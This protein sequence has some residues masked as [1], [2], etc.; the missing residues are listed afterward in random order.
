[1]VNY[2]TPELAEELRKLRQQHRKATERATAAILDEG[3]ASEAYQ[4]ADVE[5]GQAWARIRQIMQTAPHWVN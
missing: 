1:M 5:A 3:M 4:S 2:I